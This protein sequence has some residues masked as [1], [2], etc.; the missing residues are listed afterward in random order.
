M[1]KNLD[2][3]I[4][5][6]NA[7][8]LLA[9]FN[10]SSDLKHND[11]KNAYKITLMTHPDKTGLDKKY[12]LFF[13]KAFKKL[14]YL[15]EYNNRLNL[16][17]ENTRYSP[18]DL[19]SNQQENDLNVSG[20]SF[21]KKQ[22]NKIFEKAK[23]YDEE[24]DSNYDDWIKNTADEVV[25]TNRASNMSEVN[26]RIQQKKKE[27]RAIVEHEDFKEMNPSGAIENS[28]S[29]RR[30]KPKYYESGLFSKMQYEDYKRAHTETV[31]PVDEEDLKSRKQFRNINELQNYRSQNISIPNKQESAKI[32]EEK[33]RLEQEDN[34]NIA[35][36]LSKQME[37]IKKSNEI[38]NSN[39]NLIM[40]D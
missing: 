16:K 9:L 28:A 1:Q 33:N 13:T 19:D 30:T 8:E 2:L 36:N 29:L 15:Y 4:N 3:N 24:Q 31:I 23:Y 27:L 12:F 7:N 18:N 21:N 35:Y 32:I 17:N 26:E 5:N 37:Q 11:I 22:F 39:F 34:M 10:V 40:N 6:Y 38:F 25:N 14:K 20:K